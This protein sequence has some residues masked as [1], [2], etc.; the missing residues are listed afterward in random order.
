MFNFRMP[1]IRGASCCVTGCGERKMAKGE[2]NM[3]GNNVDDDEQLTIKR[4]FPRTFHR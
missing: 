1:S 2:S 3:G 4:M